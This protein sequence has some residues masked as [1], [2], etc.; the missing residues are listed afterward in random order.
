MLKIKIMNE[1]VIGLITFIVSF[2]L[3]FC[4]WGYKKSYII[5]NLDFVKCFITMTLFAL[6]AGFIFGSEYV[7]L[8]VLISFG[9]WVGQY[10]GKDQ[11]QYKL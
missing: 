10:S 4:L 3:G 8:A 2:L 1:Y 7:S 11:G 6:A 5:K 9:F